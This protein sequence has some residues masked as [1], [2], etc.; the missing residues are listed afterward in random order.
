MDT[1]GNYLE[2]EEVSQSVKAMEEKVVKDA[3]ENYLKKKEI[4]HLLQ[5]M[6]R[7]DESGRGKKESLS[8]QLRKYWEER[9]Y[10]M[11]VKERKEEHCQKLDQRSE[12]GSEEDVS[13]DK[14]REELDGR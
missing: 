12:D 4:S 5:E 6:V 14:T 1:L 10:Q 13:E 8:G 2:E 11:D 3:S 9:G 7:R